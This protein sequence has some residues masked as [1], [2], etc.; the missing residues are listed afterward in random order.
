MPFAALMADPLA[1]AHHVLDAIG[2]AAGFDEGPLRAYLDHNR[3]QRHGAHSYTAEEFGL[4]AGEL[5]RDFAFYPE[6]GP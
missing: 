1:V 5:A 3:T 4:S 6:A 2:L